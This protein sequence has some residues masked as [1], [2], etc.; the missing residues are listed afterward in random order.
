MKLH[1]L[2]CPLWPGEEQAHTPDADGLR[3]IIRQ[4]PSWDVVEPV[5]EAAADV[6]DDLTRELASALATNTRRTREVEQLS[7]NALLT[8]GALLEVAGGRVEIPDRVMEDL[9]GHAEVVRWE[10]RS[11]GVTVYELHTKWRDADG[12]HTDLRPPGGGVAG[13]PRTA[14]G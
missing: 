9:L 4:H 2:N 1:T 5:M 14:G 7:Q 13:D 6:I 8:V 12:E 3:A 11:K 10:D